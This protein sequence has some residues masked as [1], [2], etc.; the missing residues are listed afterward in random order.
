M[1]AN[2]PKPLLSG[3]SGPLKGETTPPGDKSISHRAVIL[4]GIAEGATVIR[5]LLEGEDVLRTVAALQAL[6]ARAEKDKDGVWRIEGRGL[7]KLHAPAGALDMGNSGTAARLLMGL[8]AGRP[9]ASSFTGDASL[10]KRPMQ[11]V[12]TPLSQ[13]GAQF[14]SVEGKLPL[15]VT[16]TAHPVPITYRLPVASAQVKSAI[17]LAALSAEGVTTVIEPQPTR[18]HSELMLRAFGAKIETAAAPDGS[19]SITLAGRPRLKA[20]EITVPADISSAAFPLVAALLRPGSEVLLKDVGLNPRRAGL[21]ETLKEMGAKIELRN[22]R[23]RSGEKVADIF[24]AGGAL[25]GVT[26]PAARAPSMIDEYPILAVAAACAHGTTR[27][28]GLAELRVKESDRLA[29]M[30]EGLKRCGV[31]AEAE[32]DNLI[33]HGAGGEVPGGSEAATAM[34]HRIAMSF[35]VLGSAAKAPVRIDD[36]GFIAT[37]FPG[38]VDLMNGLG[39]KIED[40]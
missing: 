7:E 28:L 39:A 24:A 17:L 21:I 33:V 23:E 31:K 2:S 20:Q 5:G 11:R 30:A 32:G 10:C 9:F 22:Q 13:M 35:L 26:V 1:P 27:M 38:F 8:L 14:R 12:I 15:T 3:A 6:G 18:D 4:G 36:G 16:G 25:K 29:L 40:V 19:E 34:D 37:S